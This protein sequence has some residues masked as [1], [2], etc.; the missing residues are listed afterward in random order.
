MNKPWVRIIL[1]IVVFAA[2]TVLPWYLSLL[3]LVSFTI[4][5]TFYLEVIFFGFLFDAL[6][7]PGTHF[8]YNALTLAFVFLLVTMFVRTRIRT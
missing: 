4:Y 2:V 6:Y 8:P 3:I 7:L 5:F 1:F